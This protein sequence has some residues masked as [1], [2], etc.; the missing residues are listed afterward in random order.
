MARVNITR[1]ESRDEF[2][3]WARRNFTPCLPNECVLF[4]VDTPVGEGLDSEVLVL[5][6]SALKNVDWDKMYDIYPYGGY[7]G[8]MY[9]HPLDCVP[10]VCAISFFPLAMMREVRGIRIVPGVGVGIMKLRDLVQLP[11]CADRRDDPEGGHVQFCKWCVP[12]QK[13][14]I[15]KSGAA[16]EALNA[17]GEQRR[18]AVQYYERMGI[19]PRDLFRVT[20]QNVNQGTKQL[21]GMDLHNSP[22]GAALAIKDR[23]LSLKMAKKFLA[24]GANAANQH[25]TRNIYLGK[26][27]PMQIAKDWHGDDSAYMAEIVPLLVKN[28]AE[29]PEEETPAVGDGTPDGK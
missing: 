9:G 3:A 11:H 20:R 14:H 26:D 6:Q 23:D 24:W 22:L 27:C 28:G 8:S 5:P 25:P 1:L 15:A 12:I 7:W 19:S 2:E 21:W 4:L 18:P 16:E 17:L 13:G 10:R 29:P